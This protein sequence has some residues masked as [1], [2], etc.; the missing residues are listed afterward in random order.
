[1][2]HDDEI[3][4]A[5]TAARELHDGEVCFVGIGSPS[6]AALLAKHRHA[7][8]LVLLYESGAIDAVPDL[9]PLSTGSPSVAAPTSYLG[10]C[11]DVFGA[12]QAGR[13]EVGML[14]AAQVDRFGNLNSTFIGGTY[15]DP[16]V[17]LVG[18]GGAHDIASLVG[19]LVI[20]MPHDPRRFVERVD[21]VTAP[22]LEP[23]G[24]RPAGTR[25]AGPVV[26]VTTRGRFTFET[27]ELTLTG[28]RPGY[29][30]DDA[31]EGLPWAVRRRD[32]LDELP[33]VEAADATLLTDLINRSEVS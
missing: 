31:L 16:K 10:D 24:S 23:D 7:P 20:V 32:E 3:W 22:G 12:L 21:Y 33:D 8:D 17:R 26:L 29:S 28:L 11:L 18:S 5:A 9:L 1:M 4:M 2:A 13:I 30:A 27:G 19:R 14:S 6:I 15:T 25:G